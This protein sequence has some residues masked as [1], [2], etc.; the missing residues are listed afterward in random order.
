MSK[1]FLIF[2]CLLIL[3]VSFA[4]EFQVASHPDTNESDTK[5]ISTI[6]QQIVQ[7]QKEIT[8]LKDVQNESS[9]LVKQFYTDKFFDY[10]SRGY[11]SIAYGIS[12]YSPDDIEQSNKED[13][14]SLVDAEVDW[15]NPESSK[16]LDIEIG[17]FVMINQNMIIDVSLGYQ[18]LQTKEVTAK[19][20][21]VGESPIFVN[22]KGTVHALV[23][24][25]APL[26]KI[27]KDILVGPGIGMGYS[28]NVKYKV[29]M[30]QGDSGE[31]FTAEGDA[32]LI[33]LFGKARYDV[34]LHTSFSLMAGYRIQE[35]ENMKIVAAE[36]LTINTDIDFDASGFFIK[37]GIVI[38]L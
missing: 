9:T 4:Q 18:F 24:R 23:L 20:T 36:L 17:K 5:S 21:Q 34:S 37:A 10:N 3:D 15:T 19:I 7:L 29:N 35:A 2:F 25:G 16:L 13:F 30:E 12:S 38:N 6:E 1:S 14:D 31:Q 8:Y 27:S 33:E 11:I 28:P 22:Q 26:F 32:M